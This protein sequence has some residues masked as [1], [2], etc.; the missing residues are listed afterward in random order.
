MELI[1]FDN[2]RELFVIGEIRDD[3]EL[4]NYY[5]IESWRKNYEQE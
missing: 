1:N 3:A 4:G 5:V 2:L